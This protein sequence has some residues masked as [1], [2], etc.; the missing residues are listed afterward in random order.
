MDPTRRTIARPKLS[1]ED[2][3]ALELDTL[4]AILPM[5]RRDAL[6]SELS[7]GELKRLEIARALALR[8][9]VI[10][11]DEPVAGCNAT[12]TAEVA[13]VIARV[14]EAGAAAVFCTR[15]EPSTSR[16]NW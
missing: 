11:L 6:A 16:A 13:D 5:D 1:S 3:R 7:Y 9:S 8:P 15:L 14:A 10:M 2:R 4:A 12:E